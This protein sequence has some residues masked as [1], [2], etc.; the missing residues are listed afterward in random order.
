MAK[1]KKTLPKDFEELLNKGN[2][3][4]LKEVFDKCELDAR[5]GYSKQSALA[6]D[7]CPH[8]LAIWLVEHGADLQ[9][10][11][12]RGNTPL[13]S[14]SRSIF[15]NI[16]SLLELSADVNDKS[17]SIGT[18]LHAAADSHNVENT[19]LLLAYGAQMDIVNSAGFTPL[20]LAL[21]TCSNIDIV[22]TAKLS[23]IYLDA[24]AQVTARMREFVVEIGKR[25]EFHRAGFNKDSVEEVSNALQ[26]LY[27][28]YG[29][30]PVAKRVL[31]DGKS[32]ITTNAK[33]WQEQ[34]QDL[35]ELLVP[36]SG[37]AETMQGEVIRITGRITHELEGNGGINW[38]EDFKKMADAFLSFVAEGRQLPAAELKEAEGL[39]T[40]V[41]RKSGDTARLCEL[42]VKW[43]LI[44]PSL[45]K[46]P[47][48]KYK[49]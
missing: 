8:E 1:K 31:H 46:L 34:H 44:N 32:P 3:Q 43:V 2:L 25:F 37:P 6:Y 13:H 19:A 33:S 4:E 5:G 38:D 21:R 39:V 20:E 9:A 48:V 10:T 7:K 40:A 14:R 27:S 18:P 30:E 15:G 24:G 42:G 17:S 45:L 29:V 41:K 16:K 35:W 23:G 22:R 36:S 28:I 11:D 12:T 47:L 49:R 26:E